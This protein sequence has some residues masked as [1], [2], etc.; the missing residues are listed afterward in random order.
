M[1]S[2][3]VTKNF[4]HTLLATWRRCRQKFAWKYVEG[5]EGKAGLGLIKGSAGHAALAEWHREYD[6]NSARDTAFKVYNAELLKNGMGMGEPEY[7]AWQDLEEALLRYFEFS[8]QTD[9][10]NLVKAELEFNISVMGE[11]FKGFIDAIIQDVNGGIWVMEHKFHKRVQ[12]KALDL[13][14]QVGLYMLAASLLGYEPQGILYN[15]IRMGG[16]KTAMRDPVVRKYLYRNP[17]GLTYVAKELQKQI[18]EI[19]DWLN[20]HPKHRIVYRNQTRDCGWDCPFYNGCL[21]IEDS[22]DATPFLENLK[23]RRNT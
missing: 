4:S 6:V 8:E 12:T 20:V 23:L 3:M 19:T 1:E 13:D 11:N 5:L 18:A 9:T 2:K 21:L 7:K 14:P 16:G 17:E 10:F 15:I 22:G